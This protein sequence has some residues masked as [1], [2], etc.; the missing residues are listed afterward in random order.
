VVFQLCLANNSFKPK[1]L[2]EGVEPRLP[3][4]EPLQQLCLHLA[5]SP[6][7]DTHTCSLP[8]SPK[9]QPGVLRSL[10]K[11][12]PWLRGSSYLHLSTSEETE[13]QRDRPKPG[14]HS[15]SQES[16]ELCR[17][18][19]LTRVQSPGSNLEQVT[20]PLFLTK[21]KRLGMVEETQ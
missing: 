14:P 11:C 2:P 9:R 20:F 19:W 3:L 17:K 21:S 7:E 10:A 16:S 15:S 8:L 1:L 4:T 12:R 18:T 13:A 6:L 5:R